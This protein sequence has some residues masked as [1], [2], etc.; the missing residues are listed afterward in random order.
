MQQI[1]EALKLIFIFR[2]ILAYTGLLNTR[3]EHSVRLLDHKDGVW[4]H[5]FN[6]SNYR[7]IQEEKSSLDM[8][9]KK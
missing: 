8:M 3:S 6:K 1:S 2:F 9:M 5:L 7:H 4:P